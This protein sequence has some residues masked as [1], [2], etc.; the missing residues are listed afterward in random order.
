MSD[1]V[2]VLKPDPL[3][4]HFFLLGEMEQGLSHEGE[5]EVHLAGFPES[6]RVRLA[7]R[8]QCQRT[9]LILE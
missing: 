1:N 5:A 9:P 7:C 3:P 4:G 2:L 6:N 8:P